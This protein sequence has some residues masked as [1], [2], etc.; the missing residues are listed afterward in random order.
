MDLCQS[1]DIYFKDIIIEAEFPRY[2][3][4][5]NFQSSLYRPLKSLRVGGLPWWSSG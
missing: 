2:P 4:K 1:E 5:I 3:A